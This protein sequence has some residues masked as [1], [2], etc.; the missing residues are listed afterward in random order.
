MDMNVNKL[1]GYM[2]LVGQEPCLLDGTIYENIQWGALDPSQV[3]K[4]QVYEAA[5]LA[6]VHTFIENLPLGYDT[7]VGEKGGMLSGGQKQR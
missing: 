1:R 7:P 5:R 3:T 6:N 4:S 2:A